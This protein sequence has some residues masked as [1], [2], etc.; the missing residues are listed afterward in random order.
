MRT[1]AIILS[2]L[3][4]IFPLEVRAESVTKEPDITKEL[5]DLAS[6]IAPA[7]SPENSAKKRREGLH[8]IMSNLPLPLISQLAFG[9]YGLKQQPPCV[10]EN[11][12]GAILSYLV[13]DAVTNYFIERPV[14]KYELKKSVPTSGGSGDSWLV[15]TLITK[16]T[17]TGR[18]SSG[19]SPKYR[20]AWSVRR[21]EGVL[22]I[23]NLSAHGLNLL[24]ILTKHVQSKNLPCPETNPR[25]R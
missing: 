16:L 9:R 6:T 7:F 18:E 24:A 2:L 5:A 11:P 1:T 13:S 19:E 4:L 15:I 23:T 12:E 21:I 10:Q 22:K 25:I 14:G 8:A 17:V 3:L 20:Y